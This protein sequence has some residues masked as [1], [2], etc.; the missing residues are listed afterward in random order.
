MKVMIMVKNCSIEDAR[1]KAEFNKLFDKPAPITPAKRG[2]A[3]RLGAVA[4]SSAGK[5][6]FAVT[7]VWLLPKGDM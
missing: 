3:A 6:W 4:G 1:Q 5:G 2:K 7:G